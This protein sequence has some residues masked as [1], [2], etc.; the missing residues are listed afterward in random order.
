MG[1]VADAVTTAVEVVLAALLGEVLVSGD[2]TRTPAPTH[3]HRTR[4]AVEVSFICFSLTQILA[5]CYEMHKL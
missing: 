2:A 5:A 4:S 3:S 1:T